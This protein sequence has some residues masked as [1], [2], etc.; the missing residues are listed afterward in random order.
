M[1]QRFTKFFF[2][3]LFVGVIVIT[4]LTSSKAWAAATETVTGTVIETM[5]AAGYTYMN[6][7]T[8]KEKHWVAIPETEIKN[9]EEVTYLQGMVMS[10]F[11]SKSLDRTFSTII[12]SPG[13]EGKMVASP[14]GTL[15]PKATKPET[16]SPDNSFAAAVQAEGGATPMAQPE[17]V[18]SGGSSGATVPLTDVK[19]EKVA[20]ENG[21]TVEEVF[22]NKE[23][24]NGKIVRIRGKVVKYNPNI[25]GKNWIH[26]QDG[27]GNPM[28]NTHDLVVT[29]TEQLSSEDI[30]VVEGKITANKDFGAGY[31]YSAIVEEA[32]LI[33]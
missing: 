13:L 31:S 16:P 19:V 30:I 9:G 26:I 4:P 2:L 10:N 22:K 23:D 5:N 12:F 20:G 3:L 29:T 18:V 27:T 17:E 6:V 15:T 1:L 14:H 7:D 28:E 21:V 8:G 24:L 32:K 11:K 33:K 25:M